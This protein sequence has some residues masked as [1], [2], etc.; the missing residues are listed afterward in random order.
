M[1]G[2]ALGGHGICLKEAA[3]IFGKAAS[4]RWKF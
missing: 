1:I 2:I 3:Y 4:Y